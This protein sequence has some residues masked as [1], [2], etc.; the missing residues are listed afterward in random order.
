MLHDRFAGQGGL[1]TNALGT[2]MAASAIACADADSATGANAGGGTLDAGGSGTASGPASAG[3]GTAAG[4]S[5]RNVSPPKPVASKPM[6]VTT[7]KR[8]TLKRTQAPAAESVSA[9]ASASVLTASTAPV[10][11]R[12]AD[13]QPPAT[14]SVPVA[15]PAALGVLPAT[16]QTP[17]GAAS[18]MTLLWGADR[19]SET[20]E[21]TE[22]TPAP[23]KQTALSEPY[24]SEIGSAAAPVAQ[25][26]MASTPS[27]S[28]ASV[29]C[30]VTNDWGSGYIANVNVTAGPSALNGWTVEFDSPNE[31]IGIWNAELVSRTETHYVVRNADWNA[32]LGAGK[33]ASFGFQANTGGAQPVGAKAV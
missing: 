6:A 26:A 21:A 2:G 20:R 18:L 32:Q 14:T 29:D 1:L 33:S 19:R 27:T 4:Q 11:A 31:I 15:V 17:V 30:Q 25:M 24:A 22:E 9:L 10:A 3:D 12:A 16:P 23:Q 5:D 8:V 28:G 7:P 13:V